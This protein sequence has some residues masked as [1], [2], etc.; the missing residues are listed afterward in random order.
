MARWMLFPVFTYFYICLSLYFILQ[1]SVYAVFSVSSSSCQLPC[2]PVC[3]TNFD[4]LRGKK[5]FAI[6]IKHQ[7]EGC[8]FFN[9]M[10]VEGACSCQRNE[11]LKLDISALA[12]KK[13]ALTVNYDP[14]FVFHQCRKA[15]YVVA[16]K[17]IK[18]TGR[19]NSSF[20]SSYACGLVSSTGSSFP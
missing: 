17:H 7:L 20:P 18:P 1:F 2:C 4:S 12:Q 6:Q 5:S 11:F 3:K 8:F 10:E 9:K 16:G 15:S 14:F 13:L 19:F